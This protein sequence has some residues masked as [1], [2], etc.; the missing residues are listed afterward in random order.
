MPRKSTTFTP[1]Q[2]SEIIRLRRGGATFTEIGKA[3]GISC[4]RA[5]YRFRQLQKAIAQAKAE[6]GS[7]NPVVDEINCIEQSH[8]GSWNAPMARGNVAREI[9]VEHN[10]ALRG[11]RAT[12]E[13][14]LRLQLISVEKQSAEIRDLRQRVAD[15]GDY[16]GRLIESND[17]LKAQVEKLEVQKADLEFQVQSLQ[18]E[19]DKLSG[20]INYIPHKI[21]HHLRVDIGAY[22]AIARALIDIGWHTAFTRDRGV[23]VLDMNGLGIA[24]DGGEDEGEAA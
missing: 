20:N 12:L 6:H 3:V 16:I 24:V 18:H 11:V 15:Q 5:R 4:P 19:N 10:K 9:C 22:N 8:D 7:G 23:L 14:K 2:D 1:Q 21:H 13:A 17:I